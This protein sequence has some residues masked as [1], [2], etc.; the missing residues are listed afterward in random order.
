MIKPP[1][2]RRSLTG[3]PLHALACFISSA[4]ARLIAD[5]LNN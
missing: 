4:L 5:H 2:Y 1:H 3:Q